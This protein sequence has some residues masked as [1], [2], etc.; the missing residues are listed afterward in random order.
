MVAH[1]HLRLCRRV[2]HRWFL[3][4][5]HPEALGIDDAVLLNEL[6]NGAGIHDTL[7]ELFELLD[8]FLEDV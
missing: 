4:G 8:V 2:L 1:T 5:R 6:G 3:V 7:R